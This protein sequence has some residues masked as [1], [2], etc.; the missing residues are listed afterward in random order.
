ML[1]RIE[2]F[3]RTN[4]ASSLTRCGTP[5]SGDASIEIKGIPRRPSPYDVPTRWSKP[6]NQRR[7]VCLE[8]DEL[9]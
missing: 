8:L 5:L 9:Q 3:K 4:I 1:D 2:Q 7:D 6:V